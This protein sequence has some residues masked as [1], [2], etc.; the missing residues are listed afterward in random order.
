MSSVFP[1]QS[2]IIGPL[3]RLLLD[4]ADTGNDPRSGPIASARPASIS[5]GNEAIVFR[6][7][8]E[9]MAR[10][11]SA[12]AKRI[13]ETLRDCE[14]ASL[15]HFSPIVWKKADGH[16]VTDIDG[17]RWIDFTSSIML[18]NVGHAHPAII[19]AVK[20]QLDAK[21]LHNYCYPTEIRMRA[22]KKVLEVSP[23]HL[24]KV[25]LLTTGAEAVECAIKLMR[26]HGQRV[27]KDKLVIVSFEQAFHGR[28]MA[29]QA[30][31]GYPEQKEWM[32]L[33]PEGFVQMPY[34]AIII[35]SREQSC[36]DPSGERV[37]ATSL[38]NL[39]RQGVKPSSIAGFLMESYHGPSCAFMDRAFVRAMRRWAD[40]HDALLTFD[41]V[42]A[43]FGRTGKWFGFQHYGVRADLVTCGKGITSSLPMSALIGRADVLDLAAP[44]T[45]SS[46][47][48]G[49]PVCCAAAIANI[50]VIQKEGLVERAASLGRILRREFRALQKKYPGRIAAVH[51]HGCAFGVVFVDPK[52]NRADVPLAERVVNRC[53]DNGLLMLQTG[54]G[55]LKLAPPLAIPESALRKGIAIIADAI[56]AELA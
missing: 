26:L 49:N 27:R 39:K 46:T 23:A 30:A 8:G 25:F 13:I 34:P 36:M 2:H 51:G 19:K 52:T 32:G 14:P 6:N 3:V 50:E 38:A 15:S 47:H 10:K 56:A 11:R 12:R 41:E 5:Q 37:F 7:V 24:D 48:T 42:Q 53:L 43:G 17:N 35:S 45:M 33:P 54:R 55:T 22:V 44:G 4:K 21:L 1:L 16:I 28:T 40:E 29:A 9:S 18:A 31:G 20:K